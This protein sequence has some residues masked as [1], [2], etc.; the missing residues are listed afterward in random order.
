MIKQQGQ[1][2]NPSDGWHD[3]YDF[4]HHNNHQNFNGI[5]NLIIYNRNACRPLTYLSEYIQIS[6]MC[7]F[8][9]HILGLG[10]KMYRVQLIFPHRGLKSLLYLKFL[11]LETLKLCHS[12]LRFRKSSACG[13]KLSFVYIQK[14]ITTLTNSRKLLAPLKIQKKLYYNQVKLKYIFFF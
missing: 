10:K 9:S 4:F 11:C 3:N 5:R 6:P 2:P 1:R 13:F 14:A 12:I 7:Y 8:Y